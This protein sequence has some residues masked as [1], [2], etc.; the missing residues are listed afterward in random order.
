[1]R[2]LR[3]SNPK[4]IDVVR[5]HLIA[6]RDYPVCNQAHDLR[7]YM[8][9]YPDSFYAILLIEDDPQELMGFVLAYIPP[10]R[11]HLFIVQA[12]LD[13]STNGTEWPLEMFKDLQAFA[14]SNDLSEIRAE[15][16]RSPK[17]FLRRWGFEEYS[18]ILALLLDQED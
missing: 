6:D 4:V 10:G 3:T 11:G 16:T 14:R 5:D 7:E 13:P 8:Q 12:W 18:T 9:A 15:T 1:M 2:L 17:A